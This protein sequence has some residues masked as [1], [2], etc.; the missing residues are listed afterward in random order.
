MVTITIVM[1]VVDILSRFDGNPNTFYSIFNNLGNFLIFMLSPILPSI[2][3]IYIYYQI[4]HQEERVK[5]LF[6]P[7]VVINLINLAILILSH[8][9]GWYYYIDSNN[10]YLRGPL[11]LVPAIITVVFLIASY[12]LIIINRNKIEKKHYYSLLFFAVPPFVCL[13]L[14]VNFYGISLMLNGVVLSIM[15]VYLNIQNHSIYTDFLTEVNNRNKLEIYL[16]EKDRIS[17][18]DKTFSAIM[19]D[20]NDFKSIN[21]TYGHDTGDEALQISAKILN[22]CIRSKDFIARLGGD[23]F[24]IVLDTD[25]MKD[26]EVIVSRMRTSFEKYNEYSY[27][28]YNISFSCGYAIYDQKYHVNIEG[29]KIHIDKL[30][31][32][33]K[34]ANKDSCI[35]QV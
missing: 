24:F 9:F 3:L 13:I 1:L 12:F 31:Y 29:L 14:Q 21:D 25:D 18:K 30:M 17:T 2:W 27:K 34:L 28:P 16:K 32:K 19:I 4:F 7:I 26:L 22:S 15:I 5:K 35:K 6:Y 33:D 10:V 8:F 23:E 20:L 11:F